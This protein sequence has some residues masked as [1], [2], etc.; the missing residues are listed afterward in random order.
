MNFK[1]GFRQKKLEKKLNINQLKLKKRG[2]ADRGFRWKRKEKKGNEERIQANFAQKLC[3]IF[4]L[5][6]SGDRSKLLARHF[7]VWAESSHFC[8]TTLPVAVD[9]TPAR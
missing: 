4:T 8:T 9:S 1:K 2:L 5:K 7:Q 3:N 6:N